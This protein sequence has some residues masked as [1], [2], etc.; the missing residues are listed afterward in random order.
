MKI[1]LPATI[2]PPR[3]RKDGS[4]A[5]SFESRELSADETHI[6]LSMRNSEGWV[7]YA[8]NEDEI[9]IP[10]E[11]AEIDEKT[12]S[13]RLRN[14]LYVYFKQESDAGRYVGNFSAFRREKMEK[15]I[16]IVKSKLE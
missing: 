11:K 4:V 8:E 13:E 15:F 1:L 14:T 12:P 7:C 5:L 16:D 3:F 10:E 9:Q 2:N 6:I